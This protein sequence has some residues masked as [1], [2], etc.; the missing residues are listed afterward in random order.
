M[1]NLT[2]FTVVNSID[3]FSLFNLNVQNK[4]TK[5]KSNSSIDFLNLRASSLGRHERYG[6]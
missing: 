1:N 5:S 2:M 4:L 6:Y 3:K